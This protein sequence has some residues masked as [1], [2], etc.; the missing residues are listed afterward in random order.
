MCREL[1]ITLEY[2]FEVIFVEI[3]PRKKNWLL[4]CGYNPGK[5]E[6]FNFLNF[7]ESKLNQ[8]GSKYERIF[9]ATLMILKL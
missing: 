1:T 3:N 4:I 9:F 2:I 5:D 7:I 8:L 6:I